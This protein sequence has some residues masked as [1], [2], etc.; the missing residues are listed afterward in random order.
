MTSRTVDGA[1]ESHER[2]DH[3][4][5]SALAAAVARLHHD[6]DDAVGS[7]QVESVWDATCHRFDA[8]PVRAFVPILAERRA[9][10]ELGTV[11]ATPRTQGPDPVEGR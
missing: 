6:F 11:A 7:A 10:K 3:Q 5:R 2:A 4:E 9:V 8:S 1:N